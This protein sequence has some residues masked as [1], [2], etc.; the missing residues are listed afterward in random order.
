[1]SSLIL[2]TGGYDETQFLGACIIT[3]MQGCEDARMR[4]NG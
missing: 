4:G 3:A 1:M 2:S